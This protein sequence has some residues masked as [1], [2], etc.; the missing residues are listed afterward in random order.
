MQQGRRQ[1]ALNPGL[2]LL[3][4]PFTEDA[5]YWNPSWIITHG[6]IETTNIADMHTSVIAIGTG[7]LLRPATFQQMI[8]KDRIGKTTAVQGLSDLL[9]PAAGIYLRAGH[10]IVGKLAGAEPA[11]RRR[12]W[13]DRLSAVAAGGDRRGGYVRAG[14]LHQPGL[15]EELRRLSLAQHRGEA[16][17]VRRSDDPV[18]RSMT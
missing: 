13:C 10:R 4:V 16:C 7:R 9:P 5:T 14:G 12:V 3:E 18:Q 2:V 15:T 11:V 8:T 6:A 17:T 1:S